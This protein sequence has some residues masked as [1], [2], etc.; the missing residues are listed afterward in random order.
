MKYILISCLVVIAFVSG[1]FLGD[2]LGMD[3]RAYYDASGKMKV[4]SSVLDQEKEKGWVEGEI[5]QQ[6]RILN[7]P[8]ITPFK[9]A[10]FLKITGNEA[11]ILEHEKYLP[12]I[13]SSLQYEKTMNLL[14]EYNE[15][16]LGKCN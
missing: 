4:L 3:S 13:E 1:I 16:Y 5:T 15:K 10:F 12:I 8:D 7:E 9:S 14:C 6:V 11:F 2:R